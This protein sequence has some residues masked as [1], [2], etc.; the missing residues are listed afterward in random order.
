MGF[1]AFPYLYDILQHNLETM[2]V[3]PSADHVTYA[4]SSIDESQLIEMKE[5]FPVPVTFP[6]MKSEIQVSYLFVF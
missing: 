2:N 4:T 1:T 5:I 3:E 6:V